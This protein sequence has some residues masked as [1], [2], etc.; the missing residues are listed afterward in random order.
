MDGFSLP[1]SQ[2]SFKNQHK[3]QLLPKNSSSSSQ[4]FVGS[5]H[6]LLNAIG[7]DLLPCLFPWGKGLHFID[8]VPLTWGSTCHMA[9]LHYF[10]AE[11]RGGRHK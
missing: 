4:L 9:D 2:S 1:N 6:P 7:T 5:V 3:C 10:S 8:H 11:G